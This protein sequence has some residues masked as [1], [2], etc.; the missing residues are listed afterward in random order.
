MK[1][2][3][4]NGFTIIELLVVMGILT[5]LLSITIIAINPAHQFKNAN[6][7]KRKSDVNSI[8]NSVSQYIADNDGTI[9]T[10]SGINDTPKEISAPSGAGKVDLCSIDT[11]GTKDFIYRY[12]AAIPTDPVPDLDPKTTANP[13]TKDSTGNC[14]TTYSTGYGI[15]SVTGTNRITVY[16]LKEPTITETR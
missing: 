10:T 16:S 9:P 15:Y 11:N 14:P 4:R 8:L 2:F 3:S 12:I 5:I 6:D 13:V 1:N 7:G